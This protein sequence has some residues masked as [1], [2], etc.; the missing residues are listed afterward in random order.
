MPS[1]YPGT[2]PSYATLVDGVDYVLAAHQNTK[3]EDIVAIATELGTDPA[4]IYTNVK[5]RLNV[6]ESLIPRA[7]ML[8]G[9]L[10]VTVASNN[11]T[12][13]VKTLAGSDPSAT[14]PVYVLL[15][16]VVR[17]ITATLSVTVSAGTNTFNAGS[18]ELKTLAVPFFVY[19]GY[20]STDGVVIGPS[21]LAHCK[22]YSDFSTTATS[23]RYCKISTITNAAAAD[24]YRV[25]G[26]FEAVNSGSAS[27]NWS[28]PA[29]VLSEPIHFS[30]EMTWTP[31]HTN[32]GGAYS[33]A[34]TVN[35][36]RY[37]V[38]YDAWLIFEHH[39]QHATPGQTNFQRFSLPFDIP[40]DVASYSPSVLATNW[41]DAKSMTAYFTTA[42]PP[43]IQI[44]LYDGSS[45]LVASKAYQVHGLLPLR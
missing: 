32:L 31:A 19:L 24:P 15:G 17:K 21:R 22:Q 36:A 14:D 34:P 7:G 30:N 2:I 41:T 12:I 44:C 29:N 9:K 4:G 26:Y 5:T 13:A 35:K 1:S 33:N 23:E 16:D 27:Y 20:N 39:T 18:N 37:Q 38:R 8:N 43:Y 10:S 3:A 42:S 25:V 40:S 11:L 45:G 28:A 6:L